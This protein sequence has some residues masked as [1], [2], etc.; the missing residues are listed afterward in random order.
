MDGAGHWRDNM[1][2]ERLWRSLKV[3][4]VYLHDLADGLMAHEVIGAWMSSYNEA[5]PHSAL[6]GCPDLR[7][8]A[9]P[10]ARAA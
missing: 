10:L 8:A 4:A 3:E 2:I 1:V 5:R 6:G 7:R 9:P